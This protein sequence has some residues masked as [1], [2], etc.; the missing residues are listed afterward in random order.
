MQTKAV[1]IDLHWTSIGDGW[2]AV[3]VVRFVDAQ[4]VEHVAEGGFASNYNLPNI[5]DQ[6]DIL[7]DPDNPESAYWTPS[8]LWFPKYTLIATFIC[9]TAIGLFFLRKNKQR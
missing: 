2:V 1:V 5:G 6:L 4:G 8:N 3:P 9:F 7:Y